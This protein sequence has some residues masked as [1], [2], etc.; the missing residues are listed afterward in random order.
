VVGGGAVTTT[1]FMLRRTPAGLAAIVL[2]MA[3]ALAAGTWARI[4]AEPLR[5]YASLAE[6]VSEGAPGATVICYHRYVQSLPYYTRRRVILVGAETE[7]RFG[8]ERAPD[9]HDYF[10][11]SDAELLRL[12]D[13]PGVKVLVLDEPDLARLGGRLGDFTIIGAEYRKRAILKRGERV[14]SN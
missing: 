14:T 10:F 11:K 2:A 6:A 3:A 12:W 7:L 9:A 8:A 5:S 13:Q 1:A 4:E